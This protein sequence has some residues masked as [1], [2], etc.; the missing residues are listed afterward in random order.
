MASPILVL[1]EALGTRLDADLLPRIYAIAGVST[2][3]IRDELRAS[4]LS[5]VDVNSDSAPDTIELARSAHLVA[6]RSSRQAAVVGVVGGVAGIA[7]IPPELAASLVLSLRLGQRLAVVYGF[8]PE[9]DSGKLVLA[10]ALAAAHGVN[11]P[12]FGRVATKVSELPLVVRGKLPGVSAAATWVGQQVVL[13]SSTTFAGRALR[14]IPG[15]AATVSG[16]A[17][18]RKHDGMARKM[19]EVFE[20][21][22][23]GERFE[24]GDVV[25]AEE[26]RPFTG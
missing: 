7:S 2:A 13:R 6:R 1:A 18:W 21:A 23:D 16:F 24:L 17:A 14:V 10:R 3:Q 12:D 20:R 15:L 11:L 25:L 22:M 5:F 19:G 8:D 4:G 26:V 9:T